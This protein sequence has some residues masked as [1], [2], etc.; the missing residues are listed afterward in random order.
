MDFPVMV[1]VIMLS[2]N[3]SHFIRDALDSVLMQET[4]FNY[5]ILIGDDASTDGTQY[6]LKEYQQ[7]Y[8]EKIHLILHDINLGTTK[9]AYKLMTLAKGK[10]LASCESDDYWTDKNK[11]QL[12]VDFLESHPNFIGCSHLVQCVDLQKQP[13]FHQKVRWI[14]SKKH[15]TLKDFKGINLPGHSCSILRKNIFLNPLYDYSILWKAH[16]F[17]GDRTCA[18]LFASQGDFFQI[19][20]TMACYRRN[21]GTDGKNVTSVLY[22]R[23]D[24]ICEELKF[25]RN[26]EIYAEKVLKVDGGFEHYRRELLVSALKMALFHHNTIFIKKVYQELKH[27]LIALLSIPWIIIKKIFSVP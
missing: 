15:Y 16:K 4:N 19:P 8:P 6:I 20:R 1:S 21:L 27:P 9:N 10:Y 3:H 26:L 5:E 17:I 25:T 7:K 12:Q 18:L 11:L 23:K 22:R 14:S 13:I 24:W 2:Y